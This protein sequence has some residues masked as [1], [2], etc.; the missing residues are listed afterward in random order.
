VAFKKAVQGKKNVGK[1]QVITCYFE[2]NK[3]KKCTLKEGCYKEGSK[4][5]T[6]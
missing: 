5:R 1:S 3:C 4:S 2:V 6:N